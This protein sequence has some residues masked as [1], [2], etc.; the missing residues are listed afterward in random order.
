MRDYARSE[1]RSG[2][3]FAAECNRAYR[4]WPERDDWVRTKNKDDDEEEGERGVRI[5]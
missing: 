4:S 1:Q 5:S 3:I 2:T